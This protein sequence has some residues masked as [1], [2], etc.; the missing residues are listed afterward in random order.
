MSSSLGGGGAGD[1]QR[2]LDLESTEVSISEFMTWGWMNPFK[3]RSGS[4]EEPLGENPR[5]ASGRLQ[6]K[7]VKQLLSE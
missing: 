7:A 1:P 6:R 2:E 4:S 5:V 3:S